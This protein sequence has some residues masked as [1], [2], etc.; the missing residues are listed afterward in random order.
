M[1]Y[2]WLL[3]IESVAL[4]VY[5]IVSEIQLARL[6]TVPVNWAVNLIFMWTFTLMS[7][8]LVIAAWHPWRI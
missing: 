7:W 4:T 2:V 1:L 8:A 6:D 3:T 5:V